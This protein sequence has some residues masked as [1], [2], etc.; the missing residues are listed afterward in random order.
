MPNEI[1]FA[2]TD[3]YG[4]WAG[5]T[6]STVPEA[7]DQTALVDDQK[8]SAEVSTAGQKKGSILTAVFGVVVLALVLGAVKK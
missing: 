5:T 2:K 8:A 4:G 1:S 7:D 3:I 6:E